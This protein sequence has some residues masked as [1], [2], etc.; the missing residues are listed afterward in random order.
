MYPVR[1]SHWLN[2]TDHCF[3]KGD[4]LCRDDNPLLF[5]LY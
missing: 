5:P 1:F 4:T 2:A 3:A